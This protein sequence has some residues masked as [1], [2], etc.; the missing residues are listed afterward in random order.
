MYRHKNQNT[1]LITGREYQVRFWVESELSKTSDT[2]H[3]VEHYPEHYEYA[4]QEGRVGPLVRL[5]APRNSAFPDHVFPINQSPEAGMWP[6]E[7]FL[8]LYEPYP[9]NNPSEDGLVLCKVV[10]SVRG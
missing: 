2:Y 8:Q 1:E 4:A 3:P 5:R 9:S 7:R 10:E 6:K